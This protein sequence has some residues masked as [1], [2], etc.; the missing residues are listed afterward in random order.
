MSKRI[1][2]MIALVIILLMLI[3]CVAAG[4]YLYNRPLNIPLSRT[5]P[6]PSPTAIS[7]RGEV[8]IEEPTQPT[9]TSTAT[10]TP[11][12]APGICGNSGKMT[13]LLTGIGIVGG[14]N[15]ADAIRFVQLD[16]D[17]RQV[18]V[19][20]FPRDL[21]LKV[22]ALDGVNARIGVAFDEKYNRTTGASEDKLLAGTDLVALALGENFGVWPEHY[23]TLRLET[24]E[25]MVD[26]IGGVE[27]TVPAALTLPDGTV[28]QPGKQV[29]DGRLSM[30]Y[31]RILNEGGE[32]E[33][34][35]RQNI[36]FK[37]LRD[38]MLSSDVITRLPALLDDFQELITTD[39]SP[40]QITE[41]ACMIEEVGTD[42]TIFYE[43]GLTTN[44]ATLQADG[45]LQPDLAQIRLFLKE[46]LNLP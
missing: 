16:F 27:V 19:V 21:F 28:I 17:Q 29:L 33:R 20:A 9:S 18:I 25:Q 45:S 2:I 5:S 35:Q 4:V 40:R 30:N 39:L 36:Y 26:T 44:L 34:L 31:I 13:L 14:D 43:V 12:A 38:K 42:K 11:V 22:S 37:A 10:A 32:A 3:L 7:Q 1:L 6:T 46:K 41:L 23:L 24:W 15:T 8:E